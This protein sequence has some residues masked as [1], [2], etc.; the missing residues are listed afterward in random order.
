M[1][2]NMTSQSIIAMYQALSQGFQLSE[3]DVIWNQDLR[4]LIWNR[5]FYRRNM[6]VISLLPIEEK[7]MIFDCL[8]TGQTPPWNEMLQYPYAL[9]GGK[10][11]VSIYTNAFFYYLRPGLYYAAN[12]ESEEYFLSSNLMDTIQFIS[13]E[14]KK[15]KHT[16]RL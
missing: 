8:G 13:M 3:L 7:Y 2:E 5:E 16:C 11:Q 12:M 9:I 1:W 15:V 6:D 14:E 4:K 10:L